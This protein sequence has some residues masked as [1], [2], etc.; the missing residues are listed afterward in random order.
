MPELRR[1]VCLI[2]VAEP[3]WI[4]RTVGT[5]KGAFGPIERC[6][7]RGVISTHSVAL[8]FEHRRL[9]LDGGYTGV[10]GRAAGG[11][12]EVDGLG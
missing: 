10:R 5:V 6:R 3:L 4:T 8:R 7:A 11:A 1:E 2:E 9:C 12:G